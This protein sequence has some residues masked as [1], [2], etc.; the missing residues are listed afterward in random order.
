M[1]Y[2]LSDVMDRA[3]VLLNDAAKTDWTY[4]RQL[5]YVQIALDELQEEFEQN[6]VA[7][8]NETSAAILI[9]AGITD[10]GYHTTPKLPNN[11]IEVQQFWEQ[12]TQGSSGYIPMTKVEFLPHYLEDQLT[13]NLVYWA[14]IDG[15]VKFLGATNDV[16]VK[17][18]Y[19]A[20]LFPRVVT[21]DTIITVINTK[22]F[23][24]YRTA[25][26]G[27]EFT[28]ENPTRAKSL[29]DDAII[30]LGRAL[31]IPTKSMQSVSTRRRPFRAAYRARQVW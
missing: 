7:A 11:L 20:S 2:P 9:P 1:D 16:Q 27:S 29:N 19:V 14:M 15:E 26:L 17:M 23:L 24:S 25:A 12:Q 13:T 30:A 22:T 21:K 31:G 6:N 28:G 5:P 8:T 4:D 18:D 10:L 3:A